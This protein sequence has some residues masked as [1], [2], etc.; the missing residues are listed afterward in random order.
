MN[1]DEFTEWYNK[2]GTV[3]ALE[4]QLHDLQE[5]LSERG[6]SSRGEYTETILFRHENLPRRDFSVKSIDQIHETGAGGH[7]FYV[8]VT[9]DG[10]GIEPNSKVVKGK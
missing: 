7:D 4:K 10:G 1:P 3:K 8:A 6:Y 2:Y 9:L 5:E